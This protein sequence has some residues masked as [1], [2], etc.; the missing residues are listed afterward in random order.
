MDSQNNLIKKIDLL[1]DISSMLMASGANTNR[2]N[3]SVNRFASVL[4]CSAYS[5]ISHKSIV[6]TLT[7]DHSNKSYTKVQSIPTYLIDFSTISSISKSSWNAMDENWTFEQIEEEISR[8]KSKKRYSRW[9]VL[10]TVSLAG[11]GFC[12]IFGGDHINVLVA[13]VS[14]FFGLYVVQESYK[15][16][17]NV[18]VRTFL[19]SLVASS[20]ASLGII[21]NLGEDS[22]IA[23][24]TSILFLVPGVPLINSFTDLLD[25]NILNGMVRFTTGLMTVLAMALGLFISML[26]FSIN[27]G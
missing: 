12:N 6:M 22:H 5:M 27:L 9:L 3:V 23:L 19:G 14:T 8:I 4:N 21:Y 13:F 1:L 25:N 2:A 20:F 16:K 7:D 15:R 24:A 18:Y 11:A 26:M 10:I 17:F